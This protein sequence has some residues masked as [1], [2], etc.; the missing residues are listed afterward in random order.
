MF[1]LY[2][3]NLKSPAAWVQKYSCQ[4]YSVMDNKVQ[5]VFATM[6]LP[7]SD[8]RHHAREH[9]LWVMSIKSPPSTRNV[10]SI[11]ETYSS[12]WSERLES[13]WRVNASFLK[14]WDE[15]KG[16]IST[17]LYTK[18]CL[19]NQW[20]KQDSWQVEACILNGLHYILKLV[21]WVKKISSFSGYHS[22]IQ[23]RLNT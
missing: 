17:L 23:F 2:F 19:G 11:G 1:F 5:G 14:T 7:L 15:G 3:L 16:G 18:H 20:D 4:T 21:N 10:S 12:F 22:L 13:I 9:A 8:F 6:T